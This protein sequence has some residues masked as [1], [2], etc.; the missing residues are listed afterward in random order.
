VEVWGEQAGGKSLS[1]SLSSLFPHA[2]PNQPCK[3]MATAPSTPKMI[4]AHP[5]VPTQGS[6]STSSS[7]VPLGLPGERLEALAVVLS[8][9]SAFGSD[10]FPHPR[11]STLHLSLYLSSDPDS[12]VLVGPWLK[13]ASGRWVITGLLGSPGHVGTGSCGTDL[14]PTMYIKGEGEA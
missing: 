12:V 4:P 5:E 11:D 10:S 13:Q 2:C 8:H 3:L 6:C 9:H 1:L 14:G 7:F